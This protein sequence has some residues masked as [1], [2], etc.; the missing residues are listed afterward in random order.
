MPVGAPIKDRRKP[1][2]TDTLAKADLQADS[3]FKRFSDSRLYDARQGSA[4][5]NE[6]NVR[7]KMLAEALPAL[8]FATGANAL[9]PFNPL[10]GQNRNVDMMTLKTSWPQ[11]RTSQ[12]DYSW[13]HSDFREVA[14]YFTQRLYKR[15]IDE[16]ELRK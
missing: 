2:K 10:G 13:R 11:E 5:A 3:F 14:F 4:A 16:G 12:K 8:S 7:T 9:A 15:F 1:A 6:D